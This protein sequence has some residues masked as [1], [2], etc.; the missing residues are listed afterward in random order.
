MKKLFAS[1]MVFATSLCFTTIQVQVK[2]LN[3]STEPV[4]VKVDLSKSS[5]RLVQPFQV[6]YNG[7]TKFYNNHNERNELL[8]VYLYTQENSIGNIV[9]KSK[10]GQLIVYA[11]T[12][13]L[14][15]FSS[16]GT[17]GYVVK[18]DSSRSLSKTPAW[19]KLWS[20]DTRRV[21]V[22]SEV[23]VTYSY[24][25]LNSIITFYFP[26]IYVESPPQEPRILSTYTE[27][28]EQTAQVELPL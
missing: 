22:P 5:G 12:T 15:F 16:L 23:N 10:G 26:S 2:D 7:N 24:D 18:K 14:D 25:S 8:P 13:E 28:V 9:L 27:Y 6:V 3:E 20:R 1:M 19:S 4:E 21:G 11:S 17:N